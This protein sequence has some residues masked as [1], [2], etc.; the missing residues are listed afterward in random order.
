[1]VTTWHLIA[2]DEHWWITYTTDTGR[3]MRRTNVVQ[4]V[5]ILHEQDGREPY[6][7]VLLDG[8][9]QPSL[10]YRIT[11]ASEPILAFLREHAPHVVA[12]L[13]ANA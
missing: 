3:R 5:V 11:G 7:N 8:T 2:D 1:M 13:E 12:K 6:L 9:L 4:A 10:G